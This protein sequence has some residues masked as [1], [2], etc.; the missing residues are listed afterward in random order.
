M[1]FRVLGAMSLCGLCGL[2]LG[3]VAFVIKLDTVESRPRQHAEGMVALTGGADRVADAI[4]LLADRRADRLLITGV[5]PGTS[6]EGLA[7]RLP[8]IRSLIDC[9]VT[10]GYQALDTAGNARETA[11]WV[12]RNHIRSLIVVTSNYHMPRAMAEIGDALSDVELMAYPVV[13]ERFKAAIWWTDLGRLRMIG[14]EYLKYLAVVIRQAVLPRTA[15][16]SSSP[17][18]SA[19]L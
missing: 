2:A 7:R 12:R 17:M 19:A 16:F 18:T 10:L 14:V 13:P 1:M 3:F 4:D 9:C 6:P 11:E 8:R 5:N 15:A